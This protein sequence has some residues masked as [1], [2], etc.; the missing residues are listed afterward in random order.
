CCNTDAAGT[1]NP[2]HVAL[3]LCHHGSCHFT[4]IL[5]CC[6]H[7][8]AIQPPCALL[9]K[10]AL[11]HNHSIPPSE[12]STQSSHVVDLKVR[13]CTPCNTAL[14]FRLMTMQIS[15]II[16]SWGSEAVAH[17]QQHAYVCTMHIQCTHL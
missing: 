16:L 8:A 17:F 10:P 12:T 5:H 1:L 9:P 6:M 13:V 15:S 7:H 14:F 11:L 4:T 2:W 3:S